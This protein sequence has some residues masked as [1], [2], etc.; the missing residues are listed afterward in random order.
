MSASSEN[1]N[2]S[3]L[4]LLLQN[5]DQDLFTRLNIG[6]IYLD[7]HNRVLCSNKVVSDLTGFTAEDILGQSYAEPCSD[8]PKSYT[9]LSDFFLSSHLL[10]ESGKSRKFMLADK[11]SNIRCLQCDVF[12]FPDRCK[13]KGGKICI[14]RVDTTPTTYDN[15]YP[16]DELKIENM[17]LREKVLSKL[18]EKALS[19]TNINILMEYALK[20]AAETLGVKYSLIMELLQ[21]GKFLLRYGYGLSGWCV[22]SIL[23]DKELGSPSGY[24]AFTGRPLVVDDMRTEERFLIPRFLHEHNV[25][26]SVTVIIGDRKNMYGVLCIHTDKQRQF[27]EHD[28]NFLQSVANILAESIKLRDSFKSLELYRNLINQSSD[29]IM[30]LNAVTKQFIY[31][32]DKVF[33]DLGYTEAEMLE[34]DIF[35]CGCFINGHHMQELIG[36]VAE[37]GSLVVESE[38]LRKDGSLFPAEIGL[39]F[40]ENEGTTYIVLIGRDI[41]ERR[42]LEH[43]IRERAKQLEYSNELKDMFADVTSHDLTGSI[44]LIEGFTGYLKEMETDGEKKHLLG[45]VVSSTAKLKKTIDSATV[46]ARLNCASDMNIEEHD[47]RLIYYSALERTLSKA[48]AKGINVELDL[49]RHC[50]ALVNPI[51]EEVLY[52]LLSNAIKYSPENGTIMVNIA[53]MDIGPEDRKWKVSISDEGPGISD[54]DKEKIFDR[55]KRAD[56]SHVAGHGLGLAIARMALKCHGEDIHVE[57][58]DNGVG[59]TFWFTVP[60]AGISES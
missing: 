44:S 51:I 45:C 56:N 15:E 13:S 32:N 42:I 14:I 5:A 30:V 16:L 19:C 59:T 24:T 21:D 6:V 28:V 18:G 55:F 11:Q 8:M 37:Q 23:V 31:V 38:I 53:P 20:I 52:N 35:D 36:Q 48:S 22:G 3:I 46:F 9:S 1:I 4:P 40:V 43:A 12:P 10:D 27:T 33:Y 7:E 58:N 54:V 60:V 50:N 17:Y 57:D 34:Q 41:S 29:L 47:L 2:D 26:S 39:A 25:V 49:P